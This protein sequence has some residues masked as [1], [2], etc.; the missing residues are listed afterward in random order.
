MFRKIAAVM[1]A[2]AL[3]LAGLAGSAAARAD[4]AANGEPF[5]QACNGEQPVIHVLVEGPWQLVTVPGGAT[6]D[7]GEAPKQGVHV[8][9][10]QSYEFVVDPDGAYEQ[11][12]FDVAEEECEGD[13]PSPPPDDE[14]TPQPTP[15]VQVPTRIDTGGGGT[16]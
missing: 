5:V 4:N 2:L 11:W 15:T 1:A 8:T 7:S 9:P 14:P 3:G 16:A 13:L 6:V 10:G 12:P